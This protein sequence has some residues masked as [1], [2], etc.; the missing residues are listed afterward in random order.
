MADWLTELSEVFAATPPTTD[1]SGTLDAMLECFRAD[2]I[3]CAFVASSAAEVLALRPLSRAANDAAAAAARTLAPK[4]GEATVSSVAIELSGVAHK[5]MAIPRST[6]RSDFVGLVVK[7]GGIEDRTEPEFWK[8]LAKQARIACRAVRL[9]HEVASLR[10]RARQLESDQ[11]SLRRAHSENVTAVI[12]ERETNLRDKRRHIEELEDEVQRRSAALREAIAKAQ[13]ANRSKT[14]YLVGMSDEIRGPITEIMQL[15]EPASPERSSAAEQR[16]AAVQI[17]RRAAYLLSIIDD[18]LDLSRIESGALV[19]TDVVAD[20]IELVSKVVETLR[21]RADEKGLEL[22][23][24]VAPETAA[25][26]VTD[27]VRFRQVLSN[28]V[29]NA[30]KFTETGFVRLEVRS[31]RDADPPSLCVSVIDSG[32]GIEAAT[33]PTLFRPF[34]KANA[35]S[36]R[37]RCGSGLGLAISRKLVGLLKGTITA[38][39]TPGTGSCFQVRLPLPIGDFFAAPALVTVSPQDG[40]ANQP[41]TNP[42]SSSGGCVIILSNDMSSLAELVGQL[43][44]R[45]L[46]FDVAPSGAALVSRVVESLATGQRPYRA[47]LIDA[48]APDLDAAATTRTL[49]RAG[50]RGRIIGLV[51]AGGGADGSTA[52][53]GADPP[54][55][56]AIIDI[57]APP[58][59]LDQALTGVFAAETGASHE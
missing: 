6:G 34:A 37:P 51:A 18:I 55:C 11:I 49:R 3:L 28:L 12:Q 32:V 54:G 16:A 10:A 17:C 29:E 41:A 47:V 52:A 5:A 20:P 53:A 39:S 36:N 58:E 2:G 4:L 25:R 27:P 24:D 1:D 26:V 45:Q 50:Y 59:I 48:L 43:G 14:E 35:S 44:R 13:A 19:I 46:R 21:P 8:T 33:L 56:D 38:A 30:I 57:A 9:S 23:L 31:E 40:T 7:E 42:P 22:Q 15:A